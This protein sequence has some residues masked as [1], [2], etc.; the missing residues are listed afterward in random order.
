MNIT[1][2][3]STLSMNSQTHIEMSSLSHVCCFVLHPYTP[4]QANEKGK[5]LIYLTRTGLIQSYDFV[6]KCR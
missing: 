5:V 4:I 3:S 1:V 6:L 2:V